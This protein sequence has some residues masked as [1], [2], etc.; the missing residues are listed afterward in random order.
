MFLLFDRWYHHLPPLITFNQKRIK[1]TQCE[2]FFSFS[3]FNFFIFLAERCTK[4]DNIYIY[5]NYQFTATRETL[6]NLL[7]RRWGASILWS[8]TTCSSWLISLNSFWKSSMLANWHKLHIEQP[9]I[10]A[11]FITLKTHQRTLM[12]INHRNKGTYYTWCP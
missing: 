12:S 5:G 6:G 8:L 11:S 10:K 9:S 7:R 4:K 2:V 1:H 3:F